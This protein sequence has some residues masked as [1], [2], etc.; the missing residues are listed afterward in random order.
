MIHLRQL[1]PAV[2]RH[3]EAYGQL[4]AAAAREM[5][6]IGRRRAMLAVVG[7]V[8]SMALVIL[9]GGTA[10]A[11]GWDTPWRW[12]VAAGVLAGLAIAT[13]GCLSAAF[14]A[15]P[16][17]THMQALREEW[18]KD[19]A[20]LSSRDRE[21]PLPSTP[22]YAGEEPRRGASDARTPTLHDA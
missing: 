2:I 6:D 15:M 18:Q 14:A 9:A 20:W 4:A 5:R 12:W 8:L 17:S 1:G 13:F 11:A 10:I 16:R 7:L 21:R 22:P 3:V 19:K